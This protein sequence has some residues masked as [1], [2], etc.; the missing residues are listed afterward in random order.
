MPNYL[1]RMFA[2]GAAGALALSLAAC[3]G[4][5]DSESPS[6]GSTGDSAEATAGGTLYYL[7]H[8]PFESADP[9]RIYYGLELANFR[10]T[11]Y[12]G[13]VAFPV[14]E[15]PVEAAT[16]VADLATDT[17]TKNEDATEW[18]F[19]LKDGVKWEDGSDI[20]C[21]DF[22]YGA[23]RVFANDL[24]TGGPNYILSYL[25][26]KDYPGPYKATEAQQAEFDKAITCD[27]KTI[28][29]KFNKPWA[30]FPLALASLSMMDPYKKD[31]DEGAKSTW[32]VLANGPYKVEGG[33]WDK[34]KGATLVRN[35]QYD[36]ATDDPSL[37]EALPD[38]I[39]YQINPS[40]TSVELIIDRVIAD[41]GNDQYAVAAPTI[42]PTRYSQIQGPVEDRAML[43]DSPYNFYLL[44][45]MK[46]M[47][48]LEVRKALAAAVDLEG[49]VKARGGEYAAT[50]AE[51]IINNGVAGYQDNPAFAGPNTGDVE[52]AKALLE[53]AGVDLPYPIT[54]TYSKSDTND[55]IAAVLKENWD[56]AGF[57]VKLDPLT[58]TYY[59]VIAKPEKESDVMM[60]GWGADWPSAMTVIPPLFDSRPN[61]SSTTCGNNYGCY[62]SDAFEAIVDQAANSTDIEE[63]NGFLQQADAQLGEDVAYI[64]L[65]ILKNYYIRGS[66]VTGYVVTPSTSM[67]PDLGAIGV[68]Q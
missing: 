58:D 68:E 42:P 33:V 19:T 2:V 50:T 34:N 51:S 17:G 39:E 5:G 63:Q 27:G 48:N 26:V 9:Q 8:Y 15:D 65:Y 13:L 57:E 43:T 64:P 52:A 62:Q 23:S 25:D 56:A 28:T 55:K 49:V 45:N 67:Y 30:D 1:K 61:F 10:R 29:Y 54:F 60:A 3:G 59:D 16:P 44:P 66:K 22:R 47:D 53:G 12:R 14:T 31:F 41:A 6:G 36:A 35:D 38:T 32:K 21:E 7:Q 37:R 11:I 46:S 24:I 40:D 20:T 4:D 18:S